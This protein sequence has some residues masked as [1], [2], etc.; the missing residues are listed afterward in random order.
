M[1]KKRTVIWLSLALIVLSALCLLLWLRP[2]EDSN[3]EHPNEQVAALFD[4]NDPDAID[5]FSIVC[6][7][8][9]ELSFSRS[10]DEW[11]AVGYPN[12]PISKVSIEALLSKLEHMLSLRTITEN[13]TDF[14]EYGLD[15]PYC[16]VRLAVG[17]SEKVY[18]FGD[19]N[20]YYTGY[21]CTIEGSNTVYMVDEDYV[22]PF[23]LTLENLLGADNLPELDGLQ[24]AEWQAVDGTAISASPDEHSEL[25]TLL[26]SIELGKWIDYGQSQYSLFGLDQPCVAKLVL[27]DDAELTLNFGL[28]ESEEYIYIR[29][30]E[31]EMIYLV[32]CSDMASLWSYVSG[33]EP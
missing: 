10:E 27:W 31:S 28:G 15:T 17:D 13:C 23:N 4:S 1:P 12:L 20:S 32:E 18:L 21:Y 11:Q 14:A 22:L 6:G 5:S 24:S 25:L 3:G 29:I 19:F 30:G 33:N 7:E 8:N 9:P 2:K 26:A 16:T